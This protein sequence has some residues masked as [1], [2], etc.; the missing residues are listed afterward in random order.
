MAESHPYVSGAGNVVQ[1][2]NHLRKSFPAT[3]KADTFKKLGIAPN[4]ESYV[5]NT[6]RFTGV[7]DAEGK[8]TSAATKAFSHIKMTSFRRHSPRW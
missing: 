3:V 8:K 6:L 5:I 1:A 4:N 2:V 7:L